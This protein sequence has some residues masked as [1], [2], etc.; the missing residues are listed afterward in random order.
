MFE[1]KFVDNYN[2]DQLLLLKKLQDIFIIR[3]INFC[4]IQNLWK[5]KILFFI[6]Q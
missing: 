3:N 6:I 1:P 4:L 5:S 2:F